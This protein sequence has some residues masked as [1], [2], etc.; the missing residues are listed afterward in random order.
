M[1]NNSEILTYLQTFLTTHRIERFKEILS[2]RTRYFT[3][4]I[5]DV[6]QPHNASAILRSCEVFGIQDV[7]IIE[8]NYVFKN[9]KQVSKN[10]NKWLNTYKYRDYKNNSLACIDILKKKGY[11][12]VATTPHT[13][14]CLLQNFDIT[15]KAAFFFGVEKEGLSDDVLKNADVALKIPMYGFT[16]SLNISV[17]AAI[18]LQHCSTKLH[19]SEID[20]QLSETEKQNLELE[21]TKKTIK[22]V[23]NIVE[24][25]LENKK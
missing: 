11:Q 10:A 19:Q 18:V 22:D 16:E 1:V 21:W 23:D 20:W 25:Y 4:A 15:K 13:D 24:R 8:K 2:Q 9:S 12:I 3:V 14:S 5:E 17:A 7:H 6:Y